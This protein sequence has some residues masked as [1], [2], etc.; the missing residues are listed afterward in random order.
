MDAVIV[1]PS[2]YVPRIQEAPLREVGADS[3]FVRAT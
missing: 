2:E 1:A 3:S